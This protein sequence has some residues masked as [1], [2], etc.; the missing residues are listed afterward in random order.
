MPFHYLRREKPT[1][2]IL[3]L[4]KKQRTTYVSKIVL[5]KQNKNSMNKTF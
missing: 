1:K 2:I 5:N 3:L 4:E